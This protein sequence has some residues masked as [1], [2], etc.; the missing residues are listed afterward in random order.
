MTNP[1]N[2]QNRL[3]QVVD[4]IKQK[5][6]EEAQSHL[7]FLLQEHPNLADAWYLASFTVEQPSRQIQ[8]LQQAL[9]LNPNHARS[10]ARLAKLRAAEIAPAVEVSEAQAPVMN[11]RLPATNTKHN[12]SSP[13]SGHTTYWITAALIGVIG[14]GLVLILALSLRPAWLNVSVNPTDGV[15]V[16]APGNPTGSAA[17]T[18]SDE[19]T[20]ERN[21][22]INPTD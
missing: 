12:G 9:Q 15:T 1:E 8:M 20:I 6:V 13:S 16:A 21:A 7:R 17:T 2:V 10:K 14:I 18:A 19:P 4:L 3:K 11:S 5:R 22:S